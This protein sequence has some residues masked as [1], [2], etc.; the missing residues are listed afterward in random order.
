MITERVKFSQFCLAPCTFK[1]VFAILIVAFARP[2]NLLEIISVVS[3]L[4]VQIYLFVDKSNDHHMELNKQTIN[5]AQNLELDKKIKIM[6]SETHLGVGKAIPAGLDWAFQEVEE[7]FIFEDDCLPSVEFF[8]YV[9]R[10]RNCL[11]GNTKMISGINL[12]PESFRPV[13]PGTSTLSSYPSIWGWYTNAQSWKDLSIYLEEAPKF[14][15]ILL[16]VLRRPTKIFSIAYFYAASIRV[17]KS[18]VQAWDCQIALAMLLHSYVSIVP[19]RNLVQNNGA[20]FVSSH[21]MTPK[22]ESSNVVA[23]FEFFNLWNQTN[24]E[25]IKIKKNDRLL[26][27]KV[28]NIRIRHLLSPL[29]VYFRNWKFK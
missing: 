29:K 7:L 3:S 23:D 28:Y 19:S 5:L 4:D 25:P 16:G 26:E 9:N 8:H 14:L 24:F 22:G 12:I 15:T 21:D 27:R 13:S 18:E 1:S 11:S 20:D 6:V 2:V 10:F 17:Y